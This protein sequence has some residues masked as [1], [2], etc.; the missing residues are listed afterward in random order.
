MPAIEP[1]EVG[2][3]FEDEAAALVLYA[4]RWFGRAEAEELVQEAFLKLVQ[5]RK[6][7]GHVRGWLYT[8]VRHA[9]ISRIRSSSRRRVR[10]EKVS[11]DGPSCFEQHPGDYLDAQAAQ[12]ALHRLSDADRE[13]VTLR[14]WGGLTL[15]EIAEMFDSSIPTVFRQYRAALGRL[16]EAMQEPCTKTTD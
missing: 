4:R 15:K 10:E 13:V 7:P 12:A 8:T 6:R 5:Q 1:S 3:W 2:R 16:R 14:I 11:D 9:A